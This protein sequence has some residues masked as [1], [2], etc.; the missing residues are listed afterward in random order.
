MRRYLYYVNRYDALVVTM[1]WYGRFALKT[2]SC[3]FLSTFRAK[4]PEELRRTIDAVRHLMAVQTY[5]LCICKRH[6]YSLPP[7]PNIDYAGQHNAFGDEVVR[8]T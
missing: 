2:L 4:L 3:R 6:Y 8:I 5:L 1:S 7:W